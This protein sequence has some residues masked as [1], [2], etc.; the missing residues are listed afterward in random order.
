MEWYNDYYLLG[1]I[2][3]LGSWVESDNVMVFRHKD[4]HFIK[5]LNNYFDKGTYS[6]E[7]KNYTQ[8]VLKVYD[9]EIDRLV[10]L[11]WSNR[12][13][14]IREL[15]IISDYKGFTRAYIELH[16]KLDYSTR[17]RRKPRKGKY[18]ALRLR[19][20]GNKNLIEGIN[21]VFNKYCGCT[22]K[23]IQNLKLNN[24]TF[25]VAYASYKEIES[26]YDW[27]WSK[28]LYNKQYWDDVEEKLKTP[29]LLL[30]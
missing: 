24:K 2:W 4:K 22:L 8:Y 17:Y 25:Y 30:E 16:S 9:F 3:G 29:V 14:D 26:I 15:P 10:K 27:L 12:N 20:Y 18:K 7:V 28:E 19:V 23:T 21:G 6:Q 5:T 1:V 11:G 13:A